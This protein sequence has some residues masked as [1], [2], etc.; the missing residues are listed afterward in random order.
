M[1]VGMGLGMGMGVGMGAGP[2]PGA[3]VV[4]LGADGTIA[5]GAR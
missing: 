2:E 4:T 3:T 5:H 1:S